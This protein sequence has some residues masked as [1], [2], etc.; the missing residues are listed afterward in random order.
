MRHAPTLAFAIVATVGLAALSAQSPSAV[1]SPSAESLPGAT[2]QE[3][4]R[5][6]EPQNPREPTPVTWSVG[7]APNARAVAGR[8]FDVMVTAKIEEGWHVYA[9]SQPAGGPIAMSVTV[10]KSQPFSLAGKVS[11]PL[12]TR[13]VDRNFPQLGETVTFE[14]KADFTVPVRVAPGT[15]I[16]SHTLKVEMEFQV[17]TDRLCLPPKTIE[18]KLDVKVGGGL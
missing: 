14:E 3:R 8:T 11:E 12:P 2:T 16:G 6:A 10:P 15:P 13:R 9:L 7:L 18:L 17:C 4:V 5:P 1:Q